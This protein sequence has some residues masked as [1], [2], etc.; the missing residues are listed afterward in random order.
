MRTREM[1]KEDY[2]IAGGSFSQLRGAARECECDA[3]TIER[4][5]AASRKNSIGSID[6]LHLTRELAAVKVPSEPQVNRCLRKKA[7]G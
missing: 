3:V 7:T 5:S 2:T 1:N 6:I 4:A